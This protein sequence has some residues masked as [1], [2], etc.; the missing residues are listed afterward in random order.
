MSEIDEKATAQTNV[1]EESAQ[2]ETAVSVG[3]VNDAIFTDGDGESTTQPEAQNTGSD[4]EK[5]AQTREERARNAQ[6][7][8]DAERKAKE[9]EDIKRQA[10]NE[11]IKEMLNGKNPYT[12]EPIV[13]D[14]DFETY[15]T[16]REIEKNGGD[17][18]MDYAKHISKKQ[19]EKIAE[20][21]A[22]REKENWYEQ[23]RKS[24][25]E[26]HPEI[27]DDLMDELIHDETF[28]AFAEKMVGKVPLNDIYDSYSK[29]VNIFDVEAKQKA[30]RM[31]AKKLST[32]S[33]LGGVSE[34]SPK[35]DFAD[36]TSAEMEE[37]I[38]RVKRGEKII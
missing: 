2:T 33:S 18:I 16:M 13:D 6:K 29:I 4:S 14:V 31:Y 10:K 24:F 36:Y 9:L 15:Q 11:G 35:K 37:A 1:A 5:S 12:D 34:P 38:A 21:K 32:P 17:P 20:E 22:S 7:R 26:A 23:D 8:R 25:R 27:T 3:D 28:S 19:K 30:E